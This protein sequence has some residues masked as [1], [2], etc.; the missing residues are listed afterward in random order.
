[1]NAK[2]VVG[3]L[4]VRIGDNNLHDNLIQPIIVYFN[5]VTVMEMAT[6]KFADLRRRFQLNKHHLEVLRKMKS[7]SNLK[8]PRYLALNTPKINTN[9]FSV[10]VAEELRTNYQAT[11]KQASESLLDITIEARRCQ[12]VTVTRGRQDNRRHDNLCHAKM[13]GGPACGSPGGKLQLLGSH[14]PCLCCS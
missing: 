12:A 11:L 6:N 4:Q 13:D 8:V 14:L 2:C 7:N 10:E 1:M 5:D 9:L 3:R